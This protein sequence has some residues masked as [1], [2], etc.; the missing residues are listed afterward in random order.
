MKLPQLFL[1]LVGQVQAVY[2]PNDNTAMA[3]V[4][5]IAS[6]ALKNNLPVFA[7]DLASVQQGAVAALAYDRFEMGP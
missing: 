2:F 3:A 1:M 7:N 6:I 5:A 4:R